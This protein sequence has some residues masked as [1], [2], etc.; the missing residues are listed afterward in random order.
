M[1]NFGEY[2]ANY[3]QRH[4][5]TISA[6]ASQSK[7][8][9]TLLSKAISGSRSLNRLTFKKLIATIAPNYYDCEI[10]TE[11]YAMTYFGKSCY[12]CIQL[13]KNNI[14]SDNVKAEVFLTTKNKPNERFQK[15]KQLILLNNTIDVRVCIESII[16]NIFKSNNPVFYSNFPD[17]CEYINRILLKEMA[18]AETKIDFKHIVKFPAN[19]NQEEELRITLQA[20][21]YLQH[22][23]STNYYICGDDKNVTASSL[24]PYYIITS[25]CIILFDDNIAGGIYITDSEVI[26]QCKSMFLKIFS[27]CHKILNAINYLKDFRETILPYCTNTYEM[28]NFGDV[29]LHFITYDSIKYFDYNNQEISAEALNLMCSTNTEMLTKFGYYTFICSKNAL[30]EF[31]YSGTIGSANAP[32]KI[33]PECKAMFLEYILQFTYKRNVQFHITD[34][35]LSSAKKHITILKSSIYKNN[36][37]FIRNAIADKNIWLESKHDA[38]TNA[39]NSFLEYLDLFSFTETQ[40]NSKNYLE[41]QISYLSKN[42]NIQNLES[43]G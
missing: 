42:K 21:T 29:L 39:Y 1:V 22:G 40:E 26:N 13:I 37:L 19:N 23:Y 20:I 6:V 14:L 3:M 31:I 33:K 27:G 38:V 5:L 15:D 43:I 35:N 11:A 25:E 9:R 30:S 10:L 7:I 12:D 2:L 24:F 17:N 32:I 41:N 16:C 8:D 34:G 4:D 28:V 36:I 18:S